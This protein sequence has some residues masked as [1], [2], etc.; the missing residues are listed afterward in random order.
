MFPTS[1]STSIHWV[2]GYTSESCTK[3][4]GYFNSRCVPSYFKY[5]TSRQAFETV[6]NQT[7]FVGTCRP[8]G[9]TVDNTGA[10]NYTATV[11]SF[12][13]AGIIQS[14]SAT[15]YRTAIVTTIAGI[16]PNPNGVGFYY[17]TKTRCIYVTSASLATATCDTFYSQSTPPFQQPSQMF[18]PCDAPCMKYPTALPSALP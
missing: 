9:S 7:L 3:T 15:G 2:L 14:S 16:Y 1:Q 12:C 4:C 17:V 13:S 8:P 11:S 5:I 18:C 6:F 10:L